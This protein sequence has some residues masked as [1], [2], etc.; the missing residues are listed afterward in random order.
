LLE[1]AGVATSSALDATVGMGAPPA[2][3]HMISGGTLVTTGNLD[4]VVALFHDE[5]GSGTIVPA[6]PG[7][8]A[9][10]VDTTAYSIIADIPGGLGPSS[11]PIRATL[12]VDGSGPRSDNCWNATAAAFRAMSQ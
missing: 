1:Y 4:V 3:S 7:L 10:S 11:Y 2:D 8:T 5:N 9:E 6:S 12:P